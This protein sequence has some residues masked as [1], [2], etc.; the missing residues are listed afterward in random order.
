MEARD[1][2]LPPGQERTAKWPVVGERAPRADDAPWTLTIGGL[3]E[4]PL[5]WGLDELLAMP[6]TQMTLDIHCV[7]RWSRFDARFSGISLAS[8][9]AQVRPCSEA[10]F[11]NFVARSERDH[12]TSLPLQ[13]A[14][15]IETLVAFRA[16][17]EPLEAIHGGPIRTVVPGRYFYK[18]LKWLT[19]IDV[20]AEN[21]LGYWE[22]ESG[23]H[24][25]AD[26]WREERFV[27][28]GVDRRL[29]RRLIESRNFRGQNF[30]GIEL[31][32]HD[33]TGLDARGAT[34][35]DARFRRAILRDADFSGANLSNA[36]FTGSDLRG[37]RFVGADLEGARFSGADLRAA[38][39]TGASLFGTAFLPPEGPGARLDAATRIDGL[40]RLGDRQRE[41]VESRL[42]TPLPSGREGQGWRGAE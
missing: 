23:Y 32:G 2:R 8:L 34:L 10:R 21:R 24:N 28:G 30:L 42:T 35:R 13:D 11:L 14:L 7:T 26:P 9:L 3:V 1:P 20:L 37:A 39:L 5:T 12:S 38:D 36:D 22:A 27:A 16:D 17:G 6:Q 4:T 33:L 40:D 29:A 41:F 25:G 18:S 31:G 15:E 19:R